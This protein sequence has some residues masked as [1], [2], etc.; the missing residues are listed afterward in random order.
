MSGAV[1]AGRAARARGAV[2]PRP[3]RGTCNRC[4]LPLRSTAWA[5]P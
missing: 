3:V 4:P 2:D 5:W 1:L